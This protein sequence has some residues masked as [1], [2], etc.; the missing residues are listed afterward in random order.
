MIYLSAN[1]RNL[2][3]HMDLR[4]VIRRMGKGR[5]F[6]LDEAVA[7]SEY[8]SLVYKEID[9]LVPVVAGG[10]TLMPY[11]EPFW[12]GLPCDQKLWFVGTGV[13][14]GHGQSASWLPGEN[15]V[16]LRSRFRGPVAPGVFEDQDFLPPPGLLFRVP[17]YQ[18][19]YVLSVVH[20]DLIDA[21]WQYILA[22]KVARK[23]GLG[24]VQC[25][26]QL[27]DRSRYSEAELVIT[28]RL[29]GAVMAAGNGIRCFALSRDRK[30][31]WFCSSAKV[32]CV[33]IDDCHPDIVPDDLVSLASSAEVPSARELEARLGKYF[34]QY[35]VRFQ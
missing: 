26:N 1:D 35:S 13:C 22:E 34:D 18:G 4:V 6:W 16:D 27:E 15:Q 28:S 33:V 30:M 14:L 12:K 8:R 7:N 24:V 32:A 5:I 23:L 20:P 19:K 31:D 11:F 29:H 9:G 21:G 17:R 25:E 3:E 2:G 10:G